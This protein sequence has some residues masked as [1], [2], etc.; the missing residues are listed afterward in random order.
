MNA[1]GAA[2]LTIR[3]PEGV[4]FSLPLA[5]PGVRLTALALDLGVV[6]VVGST[7][8]K[9]LG[10]LSFVSSDLA[11]AM[12]AVAYFVVT[13]VYGMVLEWAWRGQTVGKRVMKLRVMDAHGGRLELSQIVL[14]NLLRPVDAL[15]VFYLVGGVACLLSSRL[16]RLGD[17]AAGTVVVRR[18]E[19]SIPDLDQLLGGRYNSMLPYT[20]LA[21]RLRQRTPPELAG[22]ALEAL[23]RR[24]EFEP[25]ARL[26]VFREV[27]KRLRELVAFPSEA[28]ETLSDE[29]YVRN[30]VEIVFGK[31]RKVSI[32]T[33]P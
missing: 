8:A 29:Q 1:V 32:R 24:E 19:L 18:E 26:T 3:V 6:S 16:Q 33:G 28:V 27:A 4:E 20:H 21:A 7:L 22:A 17:M 13:L 5:G 25:E 9:A 14:R 10:L 31:G 11:Q 2:R 12:T 23:T 30:A 15:P